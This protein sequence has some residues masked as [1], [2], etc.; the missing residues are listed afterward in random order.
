MKNLIVIIALLLSTT[1]IRAQTDTLFW[2]AAPEVTIGSAIFDRPIKLRITSYSQASVVTISQPASGTFPAQIVNIPSNS[3]VSVDLTTWI[4]SIENKPP[5]TI[6]NYGL[7]IQST[8]PI[9]VYYEVVSANCLCSPEIFV[10]KGQTALGIDFWIPSQNLVNNDQQYPP[11]TNSSFDIVATEDNSIVTITP[12]HNITGHTANIPFSIIL[13]K[14][15]TYSAMATSGLAAQHLHGSRVISNK[16]IAIT[17]KDDVMQGFMY[18]S[19][20][21]LGGDQIVPTSA[22][23]TEYIAIDGF[24]NNIGDQIFILGTEDTTTVSQNGILVNTINAGQTIQLDV[25]DSATYIQTSHPVYVLQIS[26]Y[27]CEMGL[28]ILPQINCTGSN[29]IALARSTS[30]SFF[31]NLLVPNGGQNNFLVN[32]VSGIINGATFK[33][34]PG[35]NGQWLSGQTLLST[36]TFPV[37]STAMISNSS[38]PFHLSVIHGGSSTGTRF[39][40]FSG[41]AGIAAN[42]AATNINCYGTN[43][44]AADL[45]VTGGASPYTYSWS[46]GAITQ[47]LNNL[48][49]GIYNVNI[50]DAN[51]CVATATTAITQPTT[52]L[53]AN[54]NT[55]TNLAGQNLIV[56][57]SA[58]LP[59]TTFGWTQVSGN[60]QQRS[61]SPSPQHLANYFFAG[62]SANAELYQNVDVSNNAVNID[63]GIAKYYF[64]AYLRSFA[65]TPTDESK[66]MLEFQNAA[67]LT[68]S[69]YDTGFSSQTNN[70]IPFIDSILAPPLTRNIRV[71]LIAVRNNGSNNDGYIDNLMLTTTPGYITSSVNAT[72]FGG[73]A[74][75]YVSG[76]TLPYTYTWNTNPVQYGATASNLAA[77]TYTVTVKDANNCSTTANVTISQPTQ[78]TA[79]ISSQ[80]NVLC[81]GNATGSAT[82]TASSGTSPY[83]FTWNTNPVQYGATAS[84]LAAGT[85][86]VTVKDA[87]NCSTTANVTITQPTQL[88][89]IISS[90]TDVL[91][92]GNATGNATVTASG[93]TSPYTFTW[94]TNPVQYGATAS[95]LAAG[96]YTVTVKDANNCTATANVTISQPTQLSAIISSQTDVLCFGN[97]TG[98]ATATA[99]GGT[100]PY[101]FTWNTNPVQYGATASNLAAGT[102]TVTV[103][104]ANNCSTTAN[105]TISQPT[106]LTA[107]ISSQTNVLC[108]GNATGSATATASSGTSPYT[109]TWNTNPVQYGATASNLAAGT[110]TVTVKDANNCSTTANVTISQ[111]TQLSANISSQTNVLCFGNATGSATVTASGGTSPYTFTWNT[112][113]VQY[114][115][116][117]SNLAA[118]TYTVTVKDANNCSTTANVTITQPTQLSANISSQ[119]DVLCFGNATGNA[120]VTASGGTSPYTFTWNTNPV[121]YGATASNLAAGTYTVT[122]KDA[123]NCTAT[124]NVTISQPTQLSAIISSQTDVLCFGNAT[125]SATA[126]ASGGTSPY[127]FTWN[128]NPVQYGATASNLAAGTYIVTVKDANNCTTTASVTITQPTQL[129]ANI[130]SQT[131]VLCFGNA[132]GSATATASSG[133]SPYTFTWNTNPVQYGA[134]ASNLAA[135]TYIVTVKDANNCTTTANVTISQPTQLSA[136]IS[137][138]TNVLCFGN[139]TGSATATASGGTSPYTFTWNTNPVQYGAT[140]SNLAAGTYTVTIKDANNCTATANVTISQPTQLSANISSQTNVLCFGNATGSATVTAS[141]GI[142]PYTFTWNTNPVQYGATASNLVAGTYTVTVKDANNC[143]ATANVTIS[144]PTQLSANISSQTDVLCFGNATGNTTVTAS[145]GTSP[146][147]FTWN[148]NPVQYGAT[149]SNLVAGTYTV[150]VKDANNCTTTANVT[151]IQPN[152]TLSANIVGTNINCNTIGAANLTV[153]GGTSPYIYSWSNGATTQ[154]LTNISAGNYNVAITDASG[155]MATAGVNITQTATLSAT[156]ASTNILCFGN[157][158]GAADLSV[159][160]GTSPYSY[161]WSNGATTQDLTGLLAGTYSVVITDSNGC[162]TSANVTITEPTLLVASS[163]ADT[164]LCNGGSTT[165]TVT[166]TGG[167]APYTGTGTFNVNQGNYTYTVTDAHGCT[168]TASISISQPSPISIYILSQQNVSCFD[169]N[170]GNVS[171]NATGGTGGLTFSWSNGQIGN[172]ISN[173]VTGVYTIFCNRC[174]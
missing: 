25:G 83:T 160:G 49:P 2:F 35:T 11:I 26:G 146:Y 28:D 46:N 107:N 17:I 60:W 65:Q 78:L 162:I 6:L 63:N 153:T 91:C 29:N 158:T 45:S 168:A 149:A 76:G 50:T 110:Y 125:G 81:F 44:G 12:S 39:G 51:S 122:V 154:D 135:G 1:L 145:G 21:D 88:S 114:G 75:V 58:E 100:S 126:T 92:F 27:G 127:T 80:T 136:N 131:N 124:A 48:A 142:S 164:I 134:T 166:A 163:T 9:S 24:L 94:N 66:V 104:D 37:G 20:S 159:T 115:A 74:S 101:T 64:Q 71:K 147:T 141:G 97:A 148:T 41:F 95:N 89:A 129:S 30:E 4:N 73:N 10:L 42:I 54:I 98:S 90:Q 130:S 56:N 99:S 68:L 53:A 96:T 108:F 8:N 77:G 62:A 57:P 106:Q 143:T 103:K 133:T 79:N 120:T 32:G 38:T 170:D 109:F 52:P 111:P 155:C 137:S 86:T 7:K 165:V 116:T 93:G 40:Y 173:L 117:A 151:I 59:P 14:G 132:T 18:G 61:S 84:N 31:I 16:P 13:N 157:A 43:T 55:Q 69:T 85:Y 113:P 152:A 36:G 19:C 33:Q 102:Y 118:G 82:A 70:W 105:V 23:G 123:N 171:V 3:L 15:Q 161:S 119:T 87:N 139:A 138:Q 67:G 47:D 72:C 140:A 34:V 169:G 174:Q 22:L 167:T 144:Q 156:I 5:N 150:T 121:Q 128:T 112:N 172:T